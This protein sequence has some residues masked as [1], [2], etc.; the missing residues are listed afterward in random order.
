[1]KSH[2]VHISRKAALMAR[3]VTSGARAMGAP[4]KHKKIFLPSLVNT[5]SR[6]KNISLPARAPHL[7]YKKYTLVMLLNNNSAAFTLHASQPTSMR[8][9]PFFRHFFTLKIK[10][11]NLAPRKIARGK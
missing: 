8:I 6:N 2:S 10:R 1:M 5:F 11:K 3:E 7:P 4:P 9:L